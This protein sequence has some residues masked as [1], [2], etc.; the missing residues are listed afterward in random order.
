MNPSLQ[1]QILQQLPKEVLWEMEVNIPSQTW[2]KE[3]GP[4]SLSPAWK[5]KVGTERFV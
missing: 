1:I 5:R 4:A 2:W 3:V